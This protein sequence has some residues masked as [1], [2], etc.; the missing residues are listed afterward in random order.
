MT[1]LDRLKIKLKEDEKNDVLKRV[2][3]DETG[4]VEFSSYKDIV[5]EILEGMEAKKSADVRLS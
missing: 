1:I 3:K 2:D 4:T 5:Y